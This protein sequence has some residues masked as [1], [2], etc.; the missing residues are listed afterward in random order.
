MQISNKIAAFMTEAAKE[1]A[2]AEEFNRPVGG[3]TRIEKGDIVTI[4]KVD[5]QKRPMPPRGMSNEEFNGLSSE[6]QAEVGIVRGW[7]EFVTDSGSLSFS[8]LLRKHKGIDWKAN[9]VNDKEVKDILT[10]KSVRPLDFLQSDECANLIGKKVK[11][12]GTYD[13]ATNYNTP[14]VHKAFIL[15]K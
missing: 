6:K 10:F 1:A 11:C 15:V 12:V 5:F 13:E 7:Y 4:Q 8:T 3:G 14:I 9:G 2:K